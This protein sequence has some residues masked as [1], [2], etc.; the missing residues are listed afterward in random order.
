MKK[1]VMQKLLS[2]LLIFIFIFSMTSCESGEE[3]I[4]YDEN[5]SLEIIEENVTYSESFIENANSRFANLMIK[6][7]EAYLDINL[8]ETQKQSISENF[9]TTVLPILY[10]IKIYEDELDSLLYAAEESITD[11]AVISPLSLYESALYTIGSRRSGILF[12]EISLE[13][14][15]FTVPFLG[16]SACFGLPSRQ[17]VA[18]NSLIGS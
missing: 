9:T 5:I 14:P 2:A 8:K 17:P 6:I 1:N 18:T 13:E 4:A 10:R 3:P 15:G 7:T 12:F 16:C 11:A